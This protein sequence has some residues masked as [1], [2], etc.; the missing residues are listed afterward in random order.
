MEHD[1]RRDDYILHVLTYPFRKVNEKVEKAEKRIHAQPTRTDAS[2]RCRLSNS[3]HFQQ[4]S[5]LEN[6][7]SRTDVKQTKNKRFIFL[8]SL[9]NFI[10]YIYYE[11][12]IGSILTAPWLSLLYI[13]LF[14]YNGILSIYPFKN[15]FDPNSKKRKKFK[16]FVQSAEK[17]KK[18]ITE[19]I[20]FSSFALEIYSELGDLVYVD[21][22]QAMH[23]Q[24]F[25]G[26]DNEGDLEQ[27]LH[28]LRP[29][30]FFIILIACTVME[31]LIFG[32]ELIDIEDFYVP[33]WVQ[34]VFNF[35]MPKFNIILIFSGI[36]TSIYL[37]IDFY[38]LVEEKTFEFYF[39]VLTPIILTTS[40]KPAIQLIKVNKYLILLIPLSILNFLEYIYVERRMSPN[41]AF[42]HLMIIINNIVTCMLV[43]DSM[44]SILNFSIKSFDDYIIDLNEMLIIIPSTIIFIA[45]ILRTMFNFGIF[46][47]LRVDGEIITIEQ[48]NI[49]DPI[50]YHDID[51]STND[52][53]VQIIDHRNYFAVLLG[54][55][56]ILEALYLRIF[57]YSYGEITLDVN[58]NK[59][60]GLID[61]FIVCEF[62]YAI[63]ISILILLVLYVLKFLY[64]VVVG[65]CTFRKDN[66][67]KILKV[68]KKTLWVK[69]FSQTLSK[70][71]KINYYD[72]IL[73]ILITLF[74]PRK[75]YKKLSQPLGP[76]ADFTSDGLCSHCCY[77]FNIRKVI[78]KF[79]I[80]VLP[81]KYA[82]EMEDLEQGNIERWRMHRGSS[83]IPVG[84]DDYM[85]N[86]FTIERKVNESPQPVQSM[87]ELSIAM[88]RQMREEKKW[89]TASD[90]KSRLVTRI[91][92][93]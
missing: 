48:S 69:D 35:T 92:L 80:E 30:E 76:I 45:T 82:K 43:I 89:R 72:K 31:L 90:K 1:K 29:T 23:V 81:K 39:C 33:A 6:V 22:V 54:G 78:D 46:M 84:V 60:M 28:L 91:S 36:L 38:R 26:E 77:C 4:L 2:G 55:L 61:H 40:I 24:K 63:F 52:C 71:T 20:F 11:I 53:N 74:N 21:T 67:E 56:Y 58:D 47:D 83:I 49:I 13:L 9:S 44:K 68:F 37:F 51:Y 34:S 93:S 19:Q 15:Y 18:F 88:L 12:I 57:D 17:N 8:K 79:F 10:K 59:V 41:N 7:R 75:L 85:V 42:D 62:S 14:W 66:I 25:L 16:N 87:R 65:L 86:R 64:W 73:S 3:L 5:I 32:Y 50:H 70:I 27:A